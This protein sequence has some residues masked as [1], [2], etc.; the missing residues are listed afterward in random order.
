MTIHQ[1]ERLFYEDILDAARAVVQ[2]A[3][4]AKAVGPKLFGAGRSIDAA[5]RLLLDC[6]NPANER[7]LDPGQLLALA[8][9]G[10]DIGCHALMNYFA[11]EAGYDIPRPISAGDEAAELIRRQAELVGEFRRLVERQEKLARPPIHSVLR[12]SSSSGADA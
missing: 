7:R 2:A 6:L 4:G 12:G 3:G 1:Q 5:A 11:A 8:R 9:I 10:R